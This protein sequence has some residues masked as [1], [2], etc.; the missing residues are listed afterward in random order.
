MTSK[1]LVLKNND[2][3]VKVGKYGDW[4]FVTTIREYDDGSFDICWDKDWQFYDS[5][6]TVEV[7]YN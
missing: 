6:A 5:T 1:I 2:V 7:R 3:R 4:Y